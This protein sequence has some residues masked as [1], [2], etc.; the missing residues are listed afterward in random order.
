MAEK[1]KQRTWRERIEEGPSAYRRGIRGHQLLMLDFMMSKGYEVQFERDIYNRP[2][3]S[4]GILKDPSRW[5]IG[6]T[7]AKVY[8]TSKLDAWRK[9]DREGEKPKPLREATSYCSASDQFTR[10]KG[11]INATAKVMREMGLSHEFA[12]PLRAGKKIARLV[13]RERKALR[14]KLMEEQRAVATGKR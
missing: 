11:N 4:E 10:R 1:K 2:M 13:A 7:K 3:S 8:L 6:H 14:K 9:G 5:L 12:A